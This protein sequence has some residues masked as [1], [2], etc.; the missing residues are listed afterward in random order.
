MFE[1]IAHRGYASKAPENTLAAFDLAVEAGFRNLELDVRL[2]ADGQAVVIHDASLERTTDGRGK[3][4]EWSFLDLRRLDAGAWFGS[5]EFAGEHVPALSEVVERYGDDCHLHV[6]LKSK[7]LDVARVAAD[8]LAPL[9]VRPSLAFDPFGV[10]GLT[11]TSFHSEQLVEFRRA[12]SGR[13]RL[14]WLVE[15]V[16]QDVVDRALRAEF[17]GVYPK[18]AR[19][20]SDRVRMLKDAGL[21]VRAWKVS[22]VGLVRSLSDLGVEAG[23]VDWPDLARELLS[24]R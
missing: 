16:D 20:T 3:V 13:C 6:E 2:S 4:R 18:A 14:G 12:A 15:E 22:E 7:N 1:I 5:G 24:R 10:P 9:L 17:H 8:E 21:S 23:T 11:V 19:V